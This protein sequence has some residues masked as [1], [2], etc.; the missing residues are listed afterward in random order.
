MSESKSSSSSKQQGN[1]S[2]VVLALLGL[3]FTTG[4]GFFLGSAIAIEQ[5]GYAVV[6]L[7]LIAAIGTFFVYN[8]LAKM[9]AEQP[10]KSSFQEYSRSAF[11]H[12]AGFSHG[13]MYWF[14]EMLVL[15]STLTALGLFTQYWFKD[16]P[17][18]VFAGG[19]ALL[20][21]GVVLLGTS[22]FEKLEET[23]AVVKMTAIIGFIV[24]ACLVI[25]GVLGQKNAHMHTPGGI[26]EVFNKGP[27]GMWTG[28]IFA[29]FAYAG[30]EVMGLM[31]TQLKNPKDAPKSGVLM[32]SIVSV[33]YVVS[34]SF[35]LV[36]AHFKDFNVNESPFISALKDLEYQTI[37]HVFNAVLIA[38]G[39][40]SLVCSLF[41]TS[42][43]MVTIAKDGDAPKIFTKVSKRKIPYPSLA[44][45]VFGMTLSVVAALLLPKSV[46]EY[47][48]T[49][50]G[51]MLVFSWM[52]MVVSA[53][54]LLKMTTWGKIQAF[55]ACAL[56]LI[57]AVGTLFDEKSRPGFFIS[58]L[59]LASIFGVAFFM[60]NKWKNKP[61]GGGGG[62]KKLQEEQE[63]EE[64][65]L[66]RLRRK[67]TNQKSR[68]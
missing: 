2:W 9:I 36:L 16:I 64:Q 50:G 21:V 41:S 42:K 55:T 13:Y 19:Y 24:L 57:A 12:W 6:V 33:L 22:G 53:Y 31:A 45:T 11:G 30:I 39:F 17:L 58:L 65:H 3:G 48:T 67:L 15:G 34:L 8:S 61:G 35:A 62:G 60:R 44:L 25:P 23:L 32:L 47:I 18:W 37:V 43:V 66:N 29:F 46:F 38:A 14:S 26:A 56:I 1:M 68:A 51:L 27:M 28:L 20:G 10:G 54:K 59:I 52:F 63:S 5:A 40:S 4:V 49:A 7:F